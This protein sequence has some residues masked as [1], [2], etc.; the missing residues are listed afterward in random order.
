MP[1]SISSWAI[2]PCKWLNLGQLSLCLTFLQVSDRIL[3]LFVLLKRVMKKQT[4]N[5]C[6]K[7][8]TLEHQC[9]HKYDCV[10]ACYVNYCC[11]EECEES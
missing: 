2:S 3:A 8:I 6:T 10:A 1:C 5:F 4:N 7:V 9:Q 11:T